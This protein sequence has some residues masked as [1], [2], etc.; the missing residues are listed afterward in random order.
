[1][2]ITEFLDRKH[3][4]P[5]LQV[6]DKTALLRELSQRAG[7]AVAID[8]QAILEAL[9]AREALGSTGVGAGIAIPHARV[10]GLQ[11]FFGYFGRLQR[12]I[13]FDAIDGRPVDLV[14][15]LLSPDRAD[16]EPLAALACISRVLRYRD[17]AAKIRAAPNEREIVD[18]LRLSETSG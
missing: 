16:A 9:Q 3:V 1:M 17:T 7:R 5:T 12:P 18:L 8:P 13:A 11:Q 2:D 10:A 15:L 14:V 6:N 4:A